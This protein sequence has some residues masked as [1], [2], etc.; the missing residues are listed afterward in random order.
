MI[1]ALED[2]RVIDLSW[3]GPGPYCTMMLADLGADVIRVQEPGLSGR[4]AASTA[5]E[6]TLPGNDPKMVAYAAHER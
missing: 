1:A 2:I 4:R 5:K 6:E 3:Q